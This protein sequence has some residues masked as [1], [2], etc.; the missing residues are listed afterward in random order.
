MKDDLSNEMVDNTTGVLKTPL[1]LMVDDNMN[2]LQVLGNIL[3]IKNYDIGVATNGKQT[4]Q[5]A[6]STIPD[7]ILLDI[8]MP[9]MDGF[10]VCRELKKNPVTKDI[11]IIFLTAKSEIDDIVKGLRYG[12]ADY[13]TKPFNSIELLA[14]VKTHLDLKFAIDAQK[15]LVDKLSSALATV[16]QLSGL[17]PIC[18]HCK[19][20]RD[21]KG[22]WSQVERYVSDHSEARFSHGICPDCI[23]THYP[24]MQKNIKTH[25]KDHDG[26]HDK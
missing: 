12:A 7:I 10:D 26:S 17:L 9:E 6:I 23:I 24:F 2:N 3:K 21:D 14:R 15:E 22:Y 11:P 13:V 20:V 25:K 19:K 5:M 18:S 4:I 8:M 16:K 1:V